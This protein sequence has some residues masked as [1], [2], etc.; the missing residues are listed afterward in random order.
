MGI[1]YYFAIWGKN[2]SGYT[3]QDIFGF[4]GGNTIY[5]FTATYAPNFPASLSS[6]IA[7]IAKDTSF[8]AT[9]I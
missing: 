9:I 6:P 1:T 2:T 3:Y 4:F 5:A 7:T 8:Y